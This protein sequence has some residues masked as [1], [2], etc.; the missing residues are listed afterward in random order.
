MVWLLYITLSTYNLE[1]S[2][3]SYIDENNCQHSFLTAASLVSVA[4]LIP[5]SYF[6]YMCV[7]FA[8]Q[9]EGLKGD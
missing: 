8:P 6:E 7:S 3:C 9:D 5:S 1:E 2:P 4:S